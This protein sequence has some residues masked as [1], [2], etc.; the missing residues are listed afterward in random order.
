M[1]GPARKPG[2]D[3]L[4]MRDDDLL[5]KLGQVARER[6]VGGRLLLD[7]RWNRLAAGTLSAEEDADLRRIAEG[8]DE[9]RAAYEAFRPLGAEFHARVVQAITAGPVPVP[10]PVPPPKPLPFPVPVRWLAAWGGAVG[11]VAATLAAVLLRLAPMPAYSLAELS[12]GYR[13]T[14]GDLT[15]EPKFGPGDRLQVV[16]SPTTAVRWPSLLSAEAFLVNGADVRQLAVKAEVDKGDG[17]VR[18]V[19]TIDPQLPAGSWTLW[20]VV[21]RIWTLPDAADVQA[22]SSASPRQELNWVAL[23]K[24]LHMQP[25]APD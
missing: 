20:L 25:R 4:G 1:D 14:R 12:G 11:A 3:D 17:R 9:G 10:A 22:F 18:V 19:G 2:K 23:P 6:P 15:E 21:G 5:R 7:E 16:L 8:S 24:T 13:T